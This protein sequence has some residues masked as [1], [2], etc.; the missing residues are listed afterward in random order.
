MCPFYD[1]VIESK[2]Y[3][4][5]NKNDLMIQNFIMLNKTSLE[6]LMA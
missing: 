3:S 6:T 1:I 2:N 5:N 4:L